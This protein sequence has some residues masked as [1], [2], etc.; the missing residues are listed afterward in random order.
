MFFR[1]LPRTD[2]SWL[3][4]YEFVYDRLRAV[5]QDMVIQ[6]IAGPAAVHILQTIAQFHIYAGYRLAIG[7]CRIMQFCYG[8]GKTP[9][10]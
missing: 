2:H 1:I 3:F 9:Y 10:V 7:L 4:L 8:A 6:R 5:R